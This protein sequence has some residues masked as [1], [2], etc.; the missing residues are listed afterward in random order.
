MPTWTTGAP[1]AAAASSV[2]VDQ[3]VREVGAALGVHGPVGGRVEQ[4]VGAPASARSPS[5][6]RWQRATPYAATHTASVSSSAAAASSAA[7]SIPTTRPSRV[8][9]LPA[10]GAFATTSITGRLHDSTRAKSRAAR[11]VPTT[12]PDTLERVPSARGW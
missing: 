8:L 9:T 7:R 2:G 5:R 11:S 6:A 12:E 1:E 10:T 4:L 3:P